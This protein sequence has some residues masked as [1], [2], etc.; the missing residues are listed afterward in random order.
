[1]RKMIHTIDNGIG[2]IE[3]IVSVLS[4]VLICIIAFVQVVMR[5][6]VSKS[7]P[8]SEE[9]IAL[10]MVVMAMFGSAR[11]IRIKA[12]TEIDLVPNALPKKAAVVLRTVTTVINLVFLVLV[13]YS[14]YVLYNKALGSGLK[15][16]YLRIPYS[17]GYTFLV[18]GGGLMVYEFMKIIK[19]RVLGTYTE[20]DAEGGSPL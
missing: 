9:I 20:I 5:Y 15:T 18:L 10:L 8:W 3:N 19:K 14:S 16:P 13:T 11:G 17:Y 1:M 2:H 7:I 4:L 12:H 6:T